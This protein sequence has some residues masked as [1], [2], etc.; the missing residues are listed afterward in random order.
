[1]PLDIKKAV[2]ALR[3]NFFVMGVL[4][5]GWAA[6]IPE[7]KSALKM[8]DGT[9]GRAL[10]GAAIGS[11]FS[12]RVIGRL[13]REL[14]TKKVFY[15]GTVIFP[16]GYL[17]VAFAHNAFFIFIGITFFCMGYLFLD[18]PLT[19]IT[20][21]LEAKADRKYLSGFHGFWS[22]GTLLA[23]FVGSFLIGRVRYSIHLSALA[24]IAFIIL[25]MSARRLEDHKVHAETSSK[26]PLPWKGNTAFIVLVVGCGMLFAQ[27]AEFGATDWSGLF[28]R[29]VLSITGQFYVGAYIAFEAG[30]ILS[31]MKGDRYIH[32]F[33]AELV[34]RLCGYAGSV[35]WL[36]SMLIGVHIHGSHKILGYIVILIGY[37]F[38]GMGVG[39]LFPGFIT[40]LGSVPGID[41]GVA[42]SRAFLIA[43]AGFA[44]VPAAIGA[45]SDLT[46]L[47]T[48]ML[49]PIV[50][51]A[52]AGLLSRIARKVPQGE[53]AE[54]V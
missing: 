26:V 7:M 9:F 8:S 52:A 33:G 6:R 42:L 36:I 48:G 16:V 37:F 30:M 21:D 53:V 47:Q 18:N 12:S 22:M 10:I 51:L 3:L 50:L 17:T 29:D 34:V 32:K 45:I 1:M 25:V 46:S 54:M 5:G 31:R 4:L 38:A 49:L 40:I 35:L 14:G 44:V 15:M 27:G 2:S 43:I 20:Q 28:L 24:I 11:L 13:I 39:P 19:I 23:A 41:M